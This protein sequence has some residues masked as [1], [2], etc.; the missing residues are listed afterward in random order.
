M[1]KNEENPKSPKSLSKDSIKVTSATF[2]VL[3]SINEKTNEVLGL[4]TGKE[5]LASKNL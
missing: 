3:I 2:F 4:D 1:S 5:V